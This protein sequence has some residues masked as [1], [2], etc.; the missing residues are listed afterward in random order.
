MLEN[1][2]LK[3]Q[4]L[5]FLENVTHHPNSA[6]AYFIFS[7]YKNNMNYTLSGCISITRDESNHGNV[8]VSNIQFSPC[9]AVQYL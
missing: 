3:K 2:C 5:I 4:K 9:I 1:V 6:A 8:Y 7:S